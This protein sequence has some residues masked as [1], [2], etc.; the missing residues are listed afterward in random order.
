MYARVT[1]SQSFLPSGVA[2]LSSSAAASHCSRLTKETV[3]PTLISYYYGRSC[4]AVPV[5]QGCVTSSIPAR[6]LEGSG[7]LVKLRTALTLLSTS[8]FTSLNDS[9]GVAVLRRRAHCWRVYSASSQNDNTAHYAMKGMLAFFR[10]R[11]TLH[12]ERLAVAAA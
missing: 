5:Y 11:T 10:Q 9:L 7:R 4:G 12:A 1:S 3:N 8:R 6:S 2:M